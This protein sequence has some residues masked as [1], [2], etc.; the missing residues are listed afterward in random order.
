MMGYRRARDI[1]ETWAIAV[2]SPN[3]RSYARAIYG[4][5]FPE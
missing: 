4:G 1:Y 3:M 5:T 2:V